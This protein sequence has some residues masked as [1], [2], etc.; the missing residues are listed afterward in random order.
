MTEKTP[1]QAMK[2]L[3]AIKLTRKMCSTVAQVTDDGGKTWKSPFV[4]HADGPAEVILPICGSDG[5]CS[6]SL[7]KHDYSKTEARV[8]AALM[9]NGVEDVEQC[10]HFEREYLG[11]F[12]GPDREKEKMKNFGTMY[13]SELTSRKG[14]EIIL[15]VIR[16]TVTGRINCTRPNVVEK[17]HRCVPRFL[18]EDIGDDAIRKIKFPVHKAKKPSFYTLRDKVGFVGF[19]CDSNN[20]FEA[21]C[22]DHLTGCL[23]WKE[24]YDACANEV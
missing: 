16:G 20:R 4:D 7:F 3:H 13:G 8:A 5:I 10:S 19:C 2:T 17:T 1:L 21:S 11:D 12:S 14:K 24:C 23:S 15:H 22:K 18:P 9:N 6:R